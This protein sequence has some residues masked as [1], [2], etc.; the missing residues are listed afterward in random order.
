[1]KRLTLVLILACA[2]SVTVATSGFAQQPSKAPREPRAP[3]TAPRFDVGQLRDM[4]L[5]A[6]YGSAWY[7]PASPLQISQGVDGHARPFR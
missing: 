4:G 6:A 5:A 2:T 7:R 3:R 1:M